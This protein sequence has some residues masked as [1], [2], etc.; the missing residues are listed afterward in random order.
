MQRLLAIFYCII[1]LCYF[2]IHD[3]VVCEHRLLS[4]L[5]PFQQLS[6]RSQP[7]HAKT[8]YTIWRL[9]QLLK[10]CL[11]PTC[12]P[13]TSGRFTSKLPSLEFLNQFYDIIFRYFWAV[14]LSQ[15]TPSYCWPTTN[16]GSPHF[17]YLFLVIQKKKHDNQIIALPTL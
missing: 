3:F 1:H 15:T 5:D 10:P 13:L 11:E 6:S 12:Q 2:A 14:L 9:N 17:R 16:F 4:Q 8:K 7:V